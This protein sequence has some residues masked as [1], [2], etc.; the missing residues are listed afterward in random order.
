MVIFWLAII[1]LSFGLFAPFNKTVIT[2]MFV[3]AL[4]VSSALFLI[5][6]LDQ[7]FDGLIQISQQP[8]RNTLDHLQR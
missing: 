4:S 3:V 7:T 5:L 2:A 1:F 8:M 6:E